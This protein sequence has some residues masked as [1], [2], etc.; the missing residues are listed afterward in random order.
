MKNPIGLCH[1]LS[2][3]SDAVEAIAESLGEVGF[4]YVS[5]VCI[6]NAGEV[7]TLPRLPVEETLQLQRDQ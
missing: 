2:R 1:T 6:V 7:K 4:E 5:E 3:V